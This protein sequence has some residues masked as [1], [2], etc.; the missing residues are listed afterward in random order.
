MKKRTLLIISII[1]NAIIWLG[2]M[3]PLYIEERV[4]GE[5]SRESALYIAF[6]TIPFMIIGVIMTG[7][8]ISPNRNGNDLVNKK[9]VIFGLVLTIGF[10]GYR[11][12]M[13]FIND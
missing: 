6:P 5:I 2:I 11:V 3:L 8:A 13:S 4:N 9:S 7:V 1:Y 12:G 10:L